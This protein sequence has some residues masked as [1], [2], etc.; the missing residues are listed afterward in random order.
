ML[1]TCLVPISRERLSFQRCD[2]SF[3]ITLHHSFL[4]ALPEEVT[5][6]CQKAD[7]QECEKRLPPLAEEFFGVALTD[8]IVD[9]AHERFLLGVILL[10]ALVLAGQL[11]LGCQGHRAGLHLGRY[12][13]ARLFKD[14]RGQGQWSLK[15]VPAR[16][17]RG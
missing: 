8:G 10:G 5:A 16:V 9:F 2:E 13:F 17:N 1:G 3:G 11:V 6:K 15:P 12:R 14:R 4:S 7:D